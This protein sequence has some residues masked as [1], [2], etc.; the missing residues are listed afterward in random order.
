M[1]EERDNQLP[2]DLTAIPPQYSEDA[3]AMRFSGRHADSLRYVALFG[4]WYEWKDPVWREDTTLNVYDLARVI[5]REASN[6]LGDKAK[7]QILA[8]IITSAKTIA[9]VE[10]MARSD[11][12]HAATKDQWDAWPWLINTPNGLFDLQSQSLVGPMQEAYSTKLA[13]VAVDFGCACPLW[14]R[15]LDR[16]M[17]GNQE[18][19]AYLQRVCG[20]CLT[21]V[22]RDHAL[23]F[24]HGNGAN[25]KSV[26]VNTL[27]GILADYHRA[28]PIEIFMET[29]NDRHPTEL[30][31]LVGARL[32]TAI[33]TEEGRRWAE[34]RIKALTGGDPVSARF[35]RQDF[36]EFTP[37]FKLMIAGNH[38]PAIRTVDEA[39]KRRLNL[40]PFTITIPKNERDPDLGAKL[41]QEWPGILSW[42]VAGC[43]EWQVGG[44]RPPAEVQ[45]ATA[46]YLE[47]EDSISQWMA[48]AG[49]WEPNH[50]ETD[51]KLFASWVSWA[52][53]SGEFVGKRKQLIEK[54]EGLGLEPHRAE[55]AR[56]HKGFRLFW[57]D[58][59][60]S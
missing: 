37:Q 55:S 24:L 59:L 20:Y 35:M 13:A 22:T 32:V 60:E 9:A 14:M 38:K 45:A 23:F 1:S 51:A 40:I 36:F 30:A 3:L 4:K 26:F 17:G 6:E 49:K 7:D 10:K 5:C 53:R 39:I 28:A 43:L 42:M 34:S 58:G 52:N 56:G 15:F 19:I 33:E 25:G 11:R 29:K 54:L 21:G 50:F 41:R 16:V 12:R 8:K 47:A 27:A 2:S 46:A 44:L 18:L 48:E 31:M 57:D